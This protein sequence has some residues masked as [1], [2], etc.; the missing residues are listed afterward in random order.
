MVL[1]F[2]ITITLIIVVGLSIGSWYFYKQTQIFELL[3]A[4]A[5]PLEIISL[6][7]TCR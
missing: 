2:P 1:Y 6:F 5:S 4:M 3:I 7:E